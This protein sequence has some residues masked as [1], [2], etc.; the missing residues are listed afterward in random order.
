MIRPFLPAKDFETAKRFYTALGFTLGYHDEGLA[1]MNHADGS[2]FVQN[3]WQKDWAENFMLGWS[4]DDLDAWYAAASQVVEKLG[5]KGPTKPEMK[6][7]GM[8]VSDFID[9]S[10]VCWHVSEKPK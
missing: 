1:V 3:Y 2:F 9:P 4:V 10:G 6:P 7:W 5:G 8:V